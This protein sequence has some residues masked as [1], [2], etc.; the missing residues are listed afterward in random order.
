MFKIEITEIRNQIT[1]EG[2]EWTV[3]GEEYKEG[4]ER[5]TKKYGYTPEIEKVTQQTRSVLIQCVDELNLA[6]VIKAINN[7]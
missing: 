6:A 2:K 1:I 4:D 3:I 5:P 7:L